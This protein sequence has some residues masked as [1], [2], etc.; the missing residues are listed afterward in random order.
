MG[1]A[2]EGFGVPVGFL[3][4]GVRQEVAGKDFSSRMRG[5]RVGCQS[6]LAAEAPWRSWQV[7]SRGMTAW[8]EAQRGG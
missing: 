3:S 5:S 6:C 2:A 7:G 8:E 4:S 1:D